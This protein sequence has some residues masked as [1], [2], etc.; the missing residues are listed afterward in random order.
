MKS[1]KY[2]L[3][4]I[5]DIRH[6][7]LRS[8]QDHKTTSVQ[9]EAIEGNEES[10][11]WIIKDETAEAFVNK[12]VSIVQKLNDDYIYITGLVTS[13]R[14]QKETTLRIQIL[15]ACWMVRK[16]E[17]N[18]TWLEEKLVYELNPPA[19]KMAS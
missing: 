3:G 7:I 9:L 2:I 1:L 18:L 16:I 10:I 6:A 15:K 5:G 4:K 11:E 14:L 19:M 12:Q 13:Q 8:R 17:G